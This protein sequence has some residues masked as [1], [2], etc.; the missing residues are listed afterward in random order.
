MD[1]EEF[2]W[3]DFKENIK[4]LHSIIK[5]IYD[6]FN[7]NYSSNIT[8]DFNLLIF[9]PNTLIK[10][11]CAKTYYNLFKYFKYG[12][13]TNLSNHFL[14][15]SYT[16][17]YDKALFETAI[18]LIF[19]KKYKSSYRCLSYNFNNEVLKNI[20]EIKYIPSLL[21]L[22]FFYLHG[23]VV[24]KDIIIFKSIHKYC[25]NTYY[26]LNTE[27]NCTHYFDDHWNLALRVNFCLLKNNLK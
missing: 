21:A 9:T 24:N 3:N 19:T 4:I 11:E 10:N 8:N 23:I 1:N 13:H 22:S 17:N 5:K 2:V 6:Y 25:F 12:L 27:Y 16:L 7:I 18:N 20:F 26:K 14:Y 15:L